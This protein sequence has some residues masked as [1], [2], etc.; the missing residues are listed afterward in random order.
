MLRCP[1]CKT[2]IEPGTE[3]CPNC[4]VKFAKKSKPHTEEQ[5]ISK[6]ETDTNTNMEEDESL[7]KQ[8]EELAA[9]KQQLNDKR[10]REAKEEIPTDNKVESSVKQNVRKEKP[11]REKPQSVREKQQSVREKQQPAREK[12]QPVRE[13]QQPETKEERLAR[14]AAAKQAAKE[15]KEKAIQERRAASPEPSGNTGGGGAVGVV[16]GL[17]ALIGVAVLAYLFIK[18]VQ[19]KY[20]YLMGIP[21]IISI[22]G[23]IAAKKKGAAVL[24][25]LLVIAAAIGSMAYVLYS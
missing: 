1:K 5:P 11:V 20:F 10:E 21:L 17:I 4:G 7:A 22:I 6:Q 19:L 24:F 25:M 13:K 12:Q 9:L 18:N 23:I 15:A 16:F 8:S 3:R 14:M 2:I